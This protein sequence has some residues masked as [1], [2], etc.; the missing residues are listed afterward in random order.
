MNYKL[1][2]NIKTFFFDVKTI[3]RTN[4]FLRIA[5]P[6]LRT[7]TIAGKPSNVLFGPFLNVT[8]FA[9]ERAEIRF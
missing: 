6:S 8:A 7:P 5:I 9:G 4:G 1:V 3:S 2:W